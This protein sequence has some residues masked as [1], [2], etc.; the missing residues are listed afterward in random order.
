MGAVPTFCISRSVEE[1]WSSSAIVEK[2][3][4]K[5]FDSR[6]FH[7]FTKAPTRAAS[8]GPGSHDVE[9]QQPTTLQLAEEQDHRLVVRSPGH[10]PRRSDHRADI[11]AKKRTDR[12]ETATELADALTAAFANRLALRLRTKADA[13]IRAMPWREV[14]TALTT[15]LAGH[16]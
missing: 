1:T 2:G 14:D 3:G 11:Y 7:N 16:R 12:F 15:Q 6:R 4:A 10:V 9:A 13:L 8:R 5:G